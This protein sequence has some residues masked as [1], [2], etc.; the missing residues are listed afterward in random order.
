MALSIPVLAGCGSG[1]TVE[2]DSPVDIPESVEVGGAT[3]QTSE[4]TVGN[5]KVDPK[6]DRITGQ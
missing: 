4:V 2:T 3:V 5:F 1:I 6:E